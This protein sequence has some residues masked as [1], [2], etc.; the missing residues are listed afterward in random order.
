MTQI[1][2]AIIICGLQ[3]DCKGNEA[4]GFMTVTDDEAGV[5][6]IPCCLQCAEYVEVKSR[7]TEETEQEQ[8][9]ADLH[10]GSGLQG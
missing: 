6:Q 2:G 4:T 1:P 10:E 5:F 7:G 9:T 3:V 8:W